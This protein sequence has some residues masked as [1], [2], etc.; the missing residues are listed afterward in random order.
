MTGMTTVGADLTSSA[1]GAPGED[2]AA[3]NSL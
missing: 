2:L 1:G 3:G